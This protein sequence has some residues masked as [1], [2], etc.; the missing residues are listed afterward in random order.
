MLL[1]V[2]VV[3]EKNFVNLDS[4]NYNNILNIKEAISQFS[5][6]LIYTGTGNQFMRTL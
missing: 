2:L 4:V 5:N 6:A 1:E 3:L